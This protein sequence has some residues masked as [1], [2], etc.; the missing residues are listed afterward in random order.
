M[1]REAELA[2]TVMLKQCHDCSYELLMRDRYCRRCGIRQQ[3]YTE[4]MLRRFGAMNTEPRYRS[5]SG[6]LVNAVTDGIAKN[7]TTQLHNPVAKGVVAGLIS[8]PIWLL[9]VL[10][11]PLDAWVATRAATT[12]M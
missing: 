6:P 10:L 3:E 9:I 8:L 4:P 7:A 2:T 12:Q 5:F 11:S 1:H